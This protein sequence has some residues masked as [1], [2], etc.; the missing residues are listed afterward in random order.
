[1]DLDVSS[2]IAIQNPQMTFRFVTGEAAEGL[3]LRPFFN[4]TF[5]YVENVVLPRFASEFPPD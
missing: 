2:D 4:A 3:P 1:M 5:D